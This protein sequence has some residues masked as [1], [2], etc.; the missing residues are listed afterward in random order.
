MGYRIG[1]KR[2]RKWAG[3]PPFGAQEEF[4]RV[5]KE[6]CWGNFREDEKDRWKWKGA[7]EEILIPIMCPSMMLGKQDGGI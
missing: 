4:S 7:F 2:R 3:S 6:A 1:K 5:L